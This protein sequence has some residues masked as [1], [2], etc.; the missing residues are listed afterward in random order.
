MLAK[1]DA[2]FAREGRTRGPDYQ[3]IITPPPGMPIEDM[4]AYTALGVHRLLP[5]LGSQRPERAAERMKEL[6]RL[7]KLAETW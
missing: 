2:A 3:I 4:Q 7:V 5:N 1:L 6:G